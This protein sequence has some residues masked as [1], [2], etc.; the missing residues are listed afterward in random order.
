MSAGHLLFAAV[1]RYISSGICWK[2][3]IFIDMF[4]DEYRRYRERVSM[5][6]PGAKT[7]LTIPRLSVRRHGYEAILEIVF[8][9]AV[10][11]EVPVRRKHG[12]LPL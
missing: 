11:V 1:T 8:V 4:G 6:L 9:G 5:L 7:D 12:L 2:S 3:A 10:E